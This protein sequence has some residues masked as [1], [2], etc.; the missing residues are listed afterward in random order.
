[1]VGMPP[2]TSEWRQLFGWKDSIVRFPNDH[3][4]IERVLL[5]VLGD[6]ERCRIISLRNRI[7]SLKRH[8]VLHRWEHICNVIGLGETPAMRERQEQL[9]YRRVSLERELASLE[10]RVA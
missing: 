1:M 6:P 3:D 8:D 7:E 2:E 10:M 5:D 4:G 9:D